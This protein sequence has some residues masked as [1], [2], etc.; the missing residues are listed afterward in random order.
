MK[1]ATSIDNTTKE[2]MTTKKKEPETIL[3]I[4]PLNMKKCV[5]RIVGNAPY[6]QHKFSAK[7]KAQIHA[8][9]E[10]GSVAKGKKMRA[11]KDFKQVYEDAKHVAE[12]GWVGIPAPSFRSAMISACRLVGYQMTKAKLSI[13]VISDGIDGEDGTPLVKIYGKVEP[14]ESHVRNETQ[15]IDLR[16]RPMWR[17][18]WSDVNIRWDGD[19]FL[20]EDVL[21]LLARAGAQVGIGEGRPD[22]KKSAGCGWGT[23]DVVAKNPEANQVPEGFDNIT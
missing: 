15:V 19:Q 8:T 21:N 18:W 23:F 10:A 17:R 1:P 16:N 20:E 11:P 2:N 12:D 5:F 7:A 4:K 9:Q 6:V 3:T 14:H 22:S 13:F